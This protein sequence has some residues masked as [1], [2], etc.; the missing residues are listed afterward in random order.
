[1]VVGTGIDIIEIDR[2]SKAIE[3]N[4][5]FVERYFTRSERE[6]FGI[7]KRRYEVIAGNFA[8]KEAF[9]KALGTGIRNF[10][11]IDVEILRDS[12]GKPYIAAHNGALHIMKEM[13]IETCHVSISHCKNYAV[14]CVIAE[15]RDFG[16]SC[17]M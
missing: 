4:E 3:K 2:I 13:Q 15:R 8:A 10:S 5:R 7:G 1:M 12:L 16:E 17:H 11:L 9:S 6:Y 14:A